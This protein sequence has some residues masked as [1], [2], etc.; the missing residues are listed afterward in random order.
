MHMTKHRDRVQIILQVQK[1]VY[2]NSC[3]IGC[4]TDTSV[5]VIGEIM[6]NFSEIKVRA[7]M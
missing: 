3:L 6:E 1:I 2:V 7:L 5:P 4:L